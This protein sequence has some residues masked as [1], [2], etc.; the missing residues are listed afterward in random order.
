MVIPTILFSVPNKARA[1][2]GVLDT[3]VA[4]PATFATATSTAAI[5]TS[6]AA[7]AAS[8]AATAT[9][10]AS[11][12]PQTVTNT[13]TT[14]KTWAQKLLEQLLMT[15]AKRVLAALTQS[16]INWINSGFH[17][18]PLFL[19][20]PD[21]FFKDIAKSEVK[22]LVDMI[23]YDTFRFPF[24]QNVALG[25]IDSYKRQLADN[26]QYTLSKVINDP[27]LLVRYRN[28]FNVG[29]WNGFL[30]NTQYPQNNYLGF[31]GII[32]QNLASRLEGTLQAPA[33]KV[34]SLLQQGMG[35]LSP[36]NCPSNPNY[37]NGVNEF[38]KPSFNYTVPYAPPVDAN[39]VGNPLEIDAYDTQYNTAKA[40]AQAAWNSPTGPNV[41]PGGLKNTTPG[42]V[43]G[44]QVMMAM[45]SSFRQSELGAALGNSL[46]AIFDA[47][48][49]HFLDK[50]LNSLASAVSP[51]P[52]ADNWSYNG[53]T[54]SGSITTGTSTVATLSIPQNVSA[55]VG[56]VTSTTI[57]GGTGPYSIQTQSSANAGV[58]TAQISSYNTLTITGVAPGQI[59]VVVNDSS[60]PIQT[61]T[62]QITINAIG[63]LAVAPANISG[64]VNNPITATISG[65]TGPYSI[66]K[67]PDEGIAIATF[68][69][70]NIV[71]IGVA[72]GITSVVIN[73]SSTPVQTVT[74]P[75][76][77]TGP[78]DLVTD[79]QNISVNIGGTATVKIS[80]GKTPYSVGSQPDTTIAT[81]Q[82][83]STGTALTITGVG[84]G[85]TT[86]IIKDSSS[87]ISSLTITVVD[88]NNPIGICVISG[89]INKDITRSDCA[90]TNG[91][92]TPNVIPVSGGS[93]PTPTVPLG[94]C[95]FTS[96]SIPN[97]PK[98]NCESMK[99]NWNQNP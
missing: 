96:Y 45:S 55:T 48:I 75:I 93:T 49:N 12:V 6:T 84:T 58:A 53:N 37:N 7:T 73:D 62:V 3:N 78:G 70:T 43:A 8:T 68:T 54:L 79:P 27:D 26:A 94:T 92:F 87:K 34:Q 56:Q 89:T 52:S 90:T 99:G 41:C 67:G 50:G 10:T 38:L 66:T 14:V 85:T 30:V 63:T 57:S 24:G 69:D 72:P 2:W 44:N 71:V 83:S 97:M 17:G 39:G 11:L 31:Q 81:A 9:S 1:Y 40:A 80:G 32:Q 19:E 65:G 23:G 25:I 88:P 47:L 46:S 5:A 76:T 28:D 98:S 95:T 82:I 13:I 59:S 15:L 29:G 22:S 61:V 86:A 60:T 21:S 16:T 35:F 36:Q 91:S 33:Q 77:I 4:D 51:S 42:S 18:S 20:N 74:V 64:D